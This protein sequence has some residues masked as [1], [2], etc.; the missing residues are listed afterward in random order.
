[1]KNKINYSSYL[2]LVLLVLFLLQF[3]LGL[4]WKWLGNLQ[5]D[6]YYKRWSGLGLALFITFQWVLTFSRVIK[7]FR[8]KSQ[9]MAVIHKWIGAISPLFFYIHSIRMGY[10]YLALLSYVF[11][12]NTLIGYINLDVIKNNNELLFKGWMIVHVALSIT[13]SILMLFHIGIVFYYK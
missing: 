13:V 9:K 12:A 7:K 11:F 6:E 8:A 4:D 5:K 10:G 2:G 1:M 3:F